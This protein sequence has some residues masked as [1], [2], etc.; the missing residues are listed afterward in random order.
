MLVRVIRSWAQPDWLRQTPGGRGVWGACRFTEDPA[1]DPDYVIVCNH[2]HADV[3]LEID[4][5]RV[6]LFVQE[7]PVAAYR[8]IRAGYRDYGRIFGPDP[9]L[10]DQPPHRCQHGCL[11][12]QVDRSY[13][14]L[15]AAPPPAK[16]VDLTW[17]TSNARYTDGHRSRLRF[18]ERLRPRVPLE[19]FGRGFRPIGDK[20]D[21][22]APARYALAIE[23]HSTPHYWTEKIADCFLAGALPLYWGDPAIADSFPLESFVWIDIDDPD[24]P[25]QVAAI[26]RSNLAER[27]RDALLEARRRVLEEHQFFAFASRAIAEHAAL[28]PAAAPRPVV[29]RHQTNLAAYYRRTPKVIQFAHA[30]RRR[31]LA[32]R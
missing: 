17:V 12:W 30:L 28:A 8:W 16:R 15:S 32:R 23:N 9:L 5:D 7:P 25:R 20:W 27:R 6:W 19:L 4:P 13:D 24:A 3:T 10:R 29:V 21:A 14:E 1:P 26:V 22:L 18:L 2:V 31:L 11:P